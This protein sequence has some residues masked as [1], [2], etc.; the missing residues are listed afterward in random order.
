M[1]NL[2]AIIA[3]LVILT[4]P[5]AIGQTIHKD[6][7]DYFVGAFARIDSLDRE[8]VDCSKFVEWMIVKPEPVPEPVKR[9]RNFDQIKYSNNRHWVYD[10]EPLTAQNGEVKWNKYLPEIVGFRF[11]IMMDFF[12]HE[13]KINVLT[14]WEPVDRDSIQYYCGQF[15]DFNT[16]IG[17][18]GVKHVT[19]FPDSSLL[20]V[21]KFAGERYGGYRFFRGVKACEFE[22]F[23]RKGWHHPRFQSEGSYTNIH[24]NFQHLTGSS[25]QVSEV[26]EY[27][28]IKYPDQKY[29]KTIDSASVR[30]IDLWEMAKK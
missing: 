27:I 17:G 7:I 11:Y 9:R 18:A 29:R 23:Y 20:L 10:W 19:V 1:R 3:L 15:G 26:S 30:I 14:V 16:S 21:V 22:E 28:S 8:S 5:F 2:T 13:R 25:Y 24:Y 4:V 6:D 12:G